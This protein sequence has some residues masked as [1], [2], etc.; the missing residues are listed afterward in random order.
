[1]IINS[2]KFVL[3]SFV[4]GVPRIFTDKEHAEINP[5]ESQFSVEDDICFLEYIRTSR[6]N[7]NI[8]QVF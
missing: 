1:M 7:I 4:T 6:I 5:F 2:Q 8:R 3:V